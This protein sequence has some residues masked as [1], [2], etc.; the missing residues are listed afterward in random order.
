VT[1]AQ[2]SAD[3]FRFTTQALNPSLTGNV[4][5]R[6]YIDGDANTPEKGL[7]IE[8]QADLTKP[9][10]RKMLDSTI[11]SLRVEF[12][13]QRTNR[14]FSASQSATIAPKAVR[15]TLLASH[16]ETHSRLLEL[17]MLFT[18]SFQFTNTNR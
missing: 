17:P 12:L 6:L 14:W 3:E 10:V 13:D 1:A 4:L 7:S 2:G 5:I 8:Y 9:L 11:D 16:P 15:V 18:S